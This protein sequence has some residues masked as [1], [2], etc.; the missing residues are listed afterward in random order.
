MLV[1]R[2]D[3]SDVLCSLPPSRQLLIATEAS[4]F[5]YK[6]HLSIKVLHHGE[7]AQVCIFLVRYL[8]LDIVE[9]RLS[10]RVVVMSPHSSRQ[11][12]KEAVAALLISKAEG[13]LRS[14]GTLYEYHYS[15]RSA[16]HD[17]PRISRSK[18]QSRLRCQDTSARAQRLAKTEPLIHTRPLEARDASAAM[19]VVDWLN[20]SHNLLNEQP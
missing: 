19:R 17:N 1:C 11:S 4:F 15:P 3:P 12:E 2:V 8:A 6:A 16:S 13:I 5:M 10:D 14:E 20:P 7:L 18:S 9:R